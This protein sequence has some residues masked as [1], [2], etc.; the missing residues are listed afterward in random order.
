MDDDEEYGGH[1]DKFRRE[2]DDAP[3]PAREERFERD[4]R[5]SFSPDRRRRSP[6]RGDFY[7]PDY[8]RDGFRP[9]PRF[10][11]RDDDYDYR[12]GDYDDGFR[13]RGGRVPNPKELKY[14]VSKRH[15]KDW[16]RQQSGTKG[17]D[18]D[19][20]RRYDMYKEDFK[21]QESLDFFHAHKEE[22]WFVEKYRSP[23]AEEY[24]AR[25]GAHK[26]ELAERFARELEEGLFDDA[27]FDEVAGSAGG[28]APDAPPADTAA[29]VKVGNPA[30]AKKC[31]FEPRKQDEEMADG[32]QKEPAS[33]TTPVAGV[34]APAGTKRPLCWSSPEDENDV[35]HKIFIKS[36]PI[37]VAR[38]TLEEEL[39]K[40]LPD[41]PPV[42]IAL[43]DPN[44]TK[45]FIR[46]GWVVFRDG[47][48]VEQVVK[49]LEKF[50][51]G[52]QEFHFAAHQVHPPRSRPLVDVFS[53]EDRIKR[54]LEQAT[55]VARA[56][57]EDYGVSGFAAVEERMSKLGL[58]K[59]VKE[60]AMDVENEQEPDPN[61][62][63][64]LDL[65]LTYLRRVHLFDYYSGMYADS[66]EDFSR[67]FPPN[68][69]PAAPAAD[70]DRPGDEF[71]ARKATDRVDARARFFGKLLTAE[72]LARLNWRDPE[73]QVHSKL[74]SMM[75]EE[76]EFR[77]RCLM[78]DAAGKDCGKLF[79][80]PEFVEKHLLLKHPEVQEAVD[81]AKAEAVYINSYVR[82]PCKITLMKDPAL[83][84]PR[85][86]GGSRGPSN[87]NSPANGGFRG[88]RGGIN[89]RLGPR[90]DSGY[91]YPPPPAAM[92]RMDRR[93][94]RDYT[95]LD[96]VGASGGDLDIS[97]D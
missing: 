91:D 31:R 3:P 5:R 74:R 26:A 82:D 66:V 90:E 89:S 72:E 70:G 55:A 87:Y 59:E 19:W 40:A 10:R 28:A 34:A 32:D 14:L 6:P 93:Q 57:D 30:T 2:R 21:L 29:T 12:G 47:T 80:A 42:R 24:R 61:A 56:L 39:A 15:F 60:E 35:K 16:M 67:K 78:K 97:Y 77:Y 69:R 86:T 96:A 48:D 17:D 79:K 94:L 37:T 23:E 46:L 41:T 73:E 33:P 18:P 85:P 27:T 1:R 20:D 88:G 64:R 71:A 13:G 51:I 4:R 54:D 50:R 83:E 22:E 92:G 95:D 44:P 81:K 53:K 45:K 36:V 49:T 58:A 25:V 9:A 76:G 84:N 68:L 52:E 8:D 63:K 7:Q 43:S 62:K 65:V 11:G 75:K 38:K